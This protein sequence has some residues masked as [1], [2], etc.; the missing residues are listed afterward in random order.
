MNIADIILNGVTSINNDNEKVINLNELLDNKNIKRDFSEEKYVLQNKQNIIDDNLSYQLFNKNNSNVIS[1]VIYIGNSYFITIVKKDQ[2]QIMNRF[3]NN[4]YVK[5]IDK[6]LNLSYI[7]A[8]PNNI[9][10]A[11][12]IILLQLNNNNPEYYEFDIIDPSKYLSCE[13]K[14]IAV[15]YEL[16]NKIHTTKIAHI[17]DNMISIDNDISLLLGCP[18]FINNILIGIYCKKNRNMCVFFRLSTI[19]GWLNTFSLINKNLS[20]D[21]S[22]YVQYSKEQMYNIILDLNKRITILENTI[23]NINK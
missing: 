9:E 16:N 21:K 23:S 8:Y 10:N 22:I 7:T 5:Y 2:Y 12:I 18:L 14:N 20:I 1:H 6:Q 15:S 17:I 4:F 19:H 3:T 11:F 13:Q